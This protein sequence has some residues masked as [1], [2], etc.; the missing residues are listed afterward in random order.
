MWLIL[1]SSKIS[2]LP[3]VPMV[4]KT[5]SAGVLEDTRQYSIRATVNSRREAIPQLHACGGPHYA[6]L[7]TRGAQLQQTGILSLTGP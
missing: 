6:F 5:G 2:S 1:I 7:A 3:V 4:S